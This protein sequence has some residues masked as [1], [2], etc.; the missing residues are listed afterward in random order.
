MNRRAPSPA[1][2]RARSLRKLRRSRAM[3]LASAR[4]V[5]ATRLDSPLAYVQ[6]AWLD[7]KAIMAMLYRHPARCR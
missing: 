6:Q 7:H 1:A 3:A 2:L 5:K 4:F